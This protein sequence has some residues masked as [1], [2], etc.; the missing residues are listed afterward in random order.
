MNKDIRLSKRLNKVCEMVS[1]GNRVADVGCDHGF[2]SIALL[3]RGISPK[4]LCMDI[5]KGPLERAKEHIEEYG[6]SESITTRLS[7][8]LREY[9]CG[10]ADTLIIAGMGG[11]LMQDILSYEREKTND[12]KEMILSPQSEIEEFRHFL[13]DNG[14]RIEDESFVY[15]EGKYYVIMKA[16]FGENVYSLSE[17]EYAY[18]P[19]LIKK[20]D[21][22][23]LEYLKCEKDKHNKLLCK[24]ERGME[25]SDDAA[26][27]RLQ[28]RYSELKKEMIKIE[29][30]MEM[31]GD[32]SQ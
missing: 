7:N 24:L 26:K 20:R 29:K 19:C 27:D 4:A 8:G 23:L 25:A 31:L 14:Y 10:E 12:F 2:V 32:D 30:V 3:L 13:Y 6:L 18:G 1:K 22:T 28:S 15:D 16:V 17:E 21:E 5:N 11:P 9:K